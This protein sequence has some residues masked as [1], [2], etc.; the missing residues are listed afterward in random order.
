MDSS[1]TTDHKSQSFLLELADIESALPGS[2]KRKL[3]GGVD[4]DTATNVI[5]NQKRPKIISEGNNANLLLQSPDPQI[6]LQSFP[7]VSDKDKEKLM[8]K[9]KL[10]ETRFKS[11]VEISS[12][13]NISF[14]DDHDSCSSDEF[15]TEDEFEVQ[16]S[17]QSSQ[18]ILVPD[19][20][21]EFPPAVNSHDLSVISASPTYQSTGLHLSMIGE[22]FHGN[23]NNNDE[24]LFVAENRDVQSKSVESQEG[25]EKRKSRQNFTSAEDK[26]L[27]EGV[28][29]FGTSINSW[30]EI[31]KW[32]N[33]KRNANQL[34]TRYRRIL[35]KEVI[36]SQQPSIVVS[37]SKPAKSASNPSEVIRHRS[38]TSLDGELQGIP[39]S[40][41]QSP[42]L[43][44]IQPITPSRNEK[45]IHEY[46]SRAS[47]VKGKEDVYISGDVL[48]KEVDILIDT[49]NSDSICQKLREQLAVRNEQIERIIR[50]NENKDQ[51]ILQLNRELEEEKARVEIL[52]SDNETAGSTI[53][54]LLKN[55]GKENKRKFQQRVNENLSRLASITIERHGVEYIERWQEGYAFADQREK[56]RNIN[57]E[58]EEVEKMRKIL[59]NMKLQVKNNPEETNLKIP[60]HS[61]IMH[62]LPENTSLKNIP[63]LEE[64]AKLRLISLK[65]D[66]NEANDEIDRLNLEREVHLREYRRLRDWEQ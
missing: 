35:K 24:S 27:K 4:E 12:R 58:R 39:K 20:N 31:V 28:E 23:F 22:S 66:E 14:E 2:F 62:W 18:R 17:P 34:R 65:K 43:K 19:S 57:S 56:L 26:I 32:S 55:F 3:W 13:E 8:Q 46:F 16:D 38:S 41:I 33:L 7:N 37:P 53:V 44:S 45:K 52:K 9:L 15:Q 60:A 11:S 21:F 25:N 63:E 54:N 50:D 47:N 6:L 29:L 64:T 10:L 40:P 42:N 51:M 59:K 36:E 48:C 49:E 30:D 61:N 5:K 1:P